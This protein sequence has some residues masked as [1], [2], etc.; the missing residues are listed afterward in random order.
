[1]ASSTSLTNVANDGAFFGLRSM[2]A[3]VSGKAPDWLNKS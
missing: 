2:S 1:M 3:I